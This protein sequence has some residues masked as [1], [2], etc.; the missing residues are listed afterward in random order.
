MF[1]QIAILFIIIFSI[2]AAQTIAPDVTD[3][4]K[5]LLVLTSDESKPEDA[6]DRMIS[7]I[8]AEV[9][10]RLGRYEVIDRNQLESI[11]D[12][13]AL[14][15]A[16][17]IAEKDIIELGS[18]ATAKE[19]MNVQITH[20]SQ[21]GVP[22]KK[23]DDEDDEDDKRGFWEVV[24]IEIVKG[25]IRAATT[26]KEDEPY[27]YNIQTIVHADIVLLD[28]ATGKTLNTFPISAMHTGGS[29][30]ESL[31]KVLNIVRWNVSRALRELYTI[32]SEVLDVDGSN[33]TLYLGSDMG[34]KRGV[35]YEI[36]R[37]D[38]KKTLQNREV[39]IP[40]RTVGL[41][42]VDRTSGDASMG[43]IVR[44]WGRVK[45]GYKAI[46]MIHPP[47]V[48]SG[49]YFTY[50]YDKQRFDRGGIYFQLRPFN[51]WGGN[52]FFGGGT[53]IDSRGRR[54]GMFTFGGG[55]IYRF[56]Y[57]PKFTLSGI[58]DF[59]LNLVFRNDDAS[60]NVTTALFAPQFGLQTEIMINR[61]LD[62]VFQAGVSGPG[63]RG[64]WKY[65]EDEGEDSES[66]NAEWD[67]RGA[68]SLD[69]A[70]LFFNISLRYLRIN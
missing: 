13:L 12:E 21:K 9:A 43:T 6:I 25:V 2:I 42:R 18:I 22:P 39:I 55:L 32:T 11:L 64:N 7:K 63:I 17:F 30:G 67:E 4:K 37:L 52:G 10:T 58:M 65:T 38:K 48:A 53:I 50:N 27:P 36:S 33:I 69:A 54:D 49:L 15:Q 61:K 3:E 31:S 46:E 45:E 41:V 47:K 70:G 14:H 8:V 60:H 16:G 59:P 40:G 26:R 56:L 35:I 23:D 5:R 19:A 57:T 28:V 20:F 68:P 24:T 1:K 29:R 51:R 66:Y 62:I 44:K 34:I